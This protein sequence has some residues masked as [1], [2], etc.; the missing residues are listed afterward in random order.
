MI[1]EAMKKSLLASIFCTVLVGSSFALSQRGSDFS[2]EKL[3]NLA[4]DVVIGKVKSKTT[5]FVGQHIETEYEVEVQETLKG[6]SYGQGAPLRVTVAGGDM[7]TP[8]LS[9]YVQG[10]PLMYQGEEVALFVR[11]A[12]P[13]NKDLAKRAHPKSK[14]LTTP[15][16]VG[17]N[18]GKFTVIT[19]PESKSK[20]VIRMN[21]ENYGLIPG[22]QSVRGAINAVTTHQIK[23]TSAPVVQLEEAPSDKRDPLETL[24][25]PID[26]KSMKI[27]AD[28]FETNRRIQS[29]GPL[30]TH[31]LEDF[32]SQVRKFAEQ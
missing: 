25:R 24:V 28:Q 23:T 4:E 10:M 29:G 1:G 30:P 15:R 22:D 3:T 9:Q 14:L 2:L 6:K 17:L 21:L 19:D 7:T 27:K 11:Q 13:V 16:I 5:S 12:Q 20:R 8:P 18:Q 26:P 32:K 31:D